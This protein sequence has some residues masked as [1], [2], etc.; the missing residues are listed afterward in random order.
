LAGIAIGI[1]AAHSAGVAPPKHGGTLSYVVTDEPSSFDGHRE[2]AS[3][4]MHPVGPYYSVLIRVNPDS[5]ASTTDFVCDLCVGKVPAPTDGGTTYTFA[6]RHDA[7]FQTGE[8]LTARDVLASYQKIIWPPKGVISARRAFYSMVESVNA[9][10][11]ATVVFK[12][13][14]PSDAFIPT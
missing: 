11:D 9:P 8:Q 2:G 7:K 14:Y 4:L 5:P 1:G 12:L 3:T 6:I 13:K 10:D